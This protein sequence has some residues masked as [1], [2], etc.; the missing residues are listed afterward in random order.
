MTLDIRKF[1]IEGPLLITPKRFSDARG[2][3]SETYSAKSLA[4]VGITL[5]FVQDNHSL[6]SERG[7]VRGLHFQAPPKA[8]AKLVRVT[9]GRIFDV[10][11]DIRKNSPTYGRHDV[12]ELSAENWHQLLIPTGFAHGFCTL[13]PATEVLYKATDYYAPEAEAGVRWN[14]PALGIVWP[15]FAGANLSAKDREL[16]TFTQL[17]SP[18][19]LGF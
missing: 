16:P 14:D 3:F 5:T 12:T 4:E 7:T 10:F 13:E 18:F 8:Q 17:D 2:F 9:R 11:V 19:V 1:P 6:S 15:Q